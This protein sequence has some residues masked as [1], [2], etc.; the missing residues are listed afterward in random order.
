MITLTLFPEA[1][2]EPTASPFCM[3]AWCMLHA[4]GLPYDLNVTS[5][6][7]KSPK[8]KFPVIELDGVAIADSEQIRMH[9]EA[10]S[11][12]EFDA[13]LSDAERA[14]SQAVIRMVEEHVY[15]AILMDRWGEDDNW[16]HVRRVFFS[17]FPWLLRGLISHTARKQALQ[18][19]QGQGMGRHTPDE[20]FERVKRDLIAIRDLL[21]DKPF[22]FGDQPTAADYSVVPMLRAAIVTPVTKPAGQFIIDDTPLMAYVTRGTDRLYPT[23][24]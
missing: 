5:D 19:L 17:A 20:R 3:K 21:G 12:S 1:F 2:G 4:S 9:V 14:V 8:G 13:G 7:R 11:G 15:F 23:G 24:V 22:L 16:A 10:I 6:P 18:A